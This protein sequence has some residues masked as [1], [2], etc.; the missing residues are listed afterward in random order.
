MSELIS[1]Y[2]SDVAATLELGR[3]IGRGLRGG[4][5]IALSGDL[6]AGKTTLAQGLVGSLGYRGEVTSP[7]FSLVQEYLG[8]TLDVFHFDFYRVE[9]EYELLDLGWDDYLDRGGLVMVEW[10]ALFPQLLPKKTR[11]LELSHKN[12]GRFIEEIAAF[13]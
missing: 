2:L 6:G 9:E 1:R 4:E 5:V 10:P 7:T 8:G 12:G 13:S 11:W 3:E